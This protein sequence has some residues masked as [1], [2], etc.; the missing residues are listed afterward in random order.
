LLVIACD[1]DAN[2]GPATG[3]PLADALSV[4]DTIRLEEAVGDSIADIG[5]FTETPDGGFVI[6]DALQARIRRYSANGELLASAGRYGSG[7]DEVRSISGVAAQIDS[8]FLTDPRNG[9]IQVLDGDLHVVRIIHPDVAPAGKLF[10]YGRGFVVHAMTGRG[11]DRAAMID[12]QGAVVWTGVPTA[13]EIVEEAYWGSVARPAIHVEEGRLLATDGLLY[14]LSVTDLQSGSTNSFG[15]P[16]P[17]YERITSVGRGAFALQVAASAVQRWYDQFTTIGGLYGFGSRE[18]RMVAVIGSR[19]VA[20]NQ[21]LF[22]KD[23]FALDVYR[24]SDLSKAYTDVHLPAGSRVLGG[25][26]YLYVLVDGPPEPWTI[27]RLAP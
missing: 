12:A 9:R 24:A 2:V 5:V 4:V 6:A 22:E 19:P 25:G 15:T 7:P 16:P 18:H 11:G 23:D 17:S 14:P 8:I 21:S 1:V 10:P 20:S 26:R 3:L 13:P 27:I